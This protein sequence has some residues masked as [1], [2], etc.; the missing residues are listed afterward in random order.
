MRPVVVMQ[1]LI[2]ERCLADLFVSVASDEAKN[3]ALGGGTEMVLKGFF[4]S[5]YRHAQQS[6]H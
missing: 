1:V 3:S 4:V 2:R 5:T 6:P